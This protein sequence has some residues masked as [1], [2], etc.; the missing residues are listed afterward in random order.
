MRETFDQCW[1]DDRRDVRVC[2]SSQKHFVTEG[3]ERA[4]EQAKAIAGN[5]QVAVASTTIVQQ[6]LKAGL[7]EEIHIDLVPILLDAGIRLF[8]PLDSPFE[9]TSTSV[10][11]STGVTHLT[12]RV[13]K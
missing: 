13:V 5:K 1:E 4:I 8:D 11:E 6:C 9:L 7:L 10:I 12:F 3:V 2:A